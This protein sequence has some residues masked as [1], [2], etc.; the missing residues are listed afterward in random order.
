MT[1]TQDSVYAVTRYDQDD[2]NGV[3]NILAM[4]LEQNLQAH[5][6]R[7][8]MARTFRR[9]VAVVSTDTNT[10]ATIIFRNDNAVICN[11][12]A[13]KPTVVV[14]ASVNQIL[15]VSQ[16][17]MKAGGLLP[18]GFFTQRGFSILSQILTRKLVVK[19]LITHPVTALRM[20]AMLSVAP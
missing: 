15:D 10:S 12:V 13:N 9:P 6:D 2:A 8:N 7:I 16:L 5:A 1:I 4:L 18:I 3:A 14:W 20:I 11:D 17:Q 19:G